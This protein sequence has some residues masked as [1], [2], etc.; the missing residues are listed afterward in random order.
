MNF[1]SFINNGKAIIKERINS[2]LL[3]SFAIS[4]LLYNWKVWYATLY[5][6]KGFLESYHS[7]LDYLDVYFQS[8]NYYKLFWYPLGTGLLLIA[9]LPFLNSLLKWIRNKQKDFDISFQDE[10]PANKSELKKLREY[11]DDKETSHSEEI[12]S[13][14]LQHKADREQDQQDHNSDFKIQNDRSREVLNAQTKI[15]DELR[16]DNGKVQ[17][18]LSSIQKMNKS[19][20]EEVE[21]LKKGLLKLENEKN[22][23]SIINDLYNFLFHEGI[24]KQEFFSI[25]NNREYWD[26]R[27]DKTTRVYT[28]LNKLGLII[29]MDILDSLDKID[30]TPSDLG[31]KVF[32]IINS[33]SINRN[34]A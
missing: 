12:L 10:L 14:R 17:S 22:L 7:R 11:L 28:R 19:L 24:S 33:P 4:W 1:S 15:T 30:L 32:N 26:I 25:L 8:A 29:N 31:S 3:F 34:K 27:N 2:Q 20:N 21:L 13:L 9:G 6:D 18:K 23:K 16:D 5:S